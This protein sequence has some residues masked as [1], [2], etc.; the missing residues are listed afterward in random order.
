MKLSNIHII[1]TFYVT[2]AS[3]IRKKDEQVIFSKNDSFFHHLSQNMMTDCPS[4]LHVEYMFSTFWSGIQITT[5]CAAKYFFWK[6]I[7]SLLNSK[8]K[9]D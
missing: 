2:N 9:I 7:F 5:D 4:S 3:K 6:F 8:C 1:S